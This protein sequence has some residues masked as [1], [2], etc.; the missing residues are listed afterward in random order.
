MR[1]HPVTQRYAPTSDQKELYTLSHYNKLLTITNYSAN[2][3]LRPLYN[4]T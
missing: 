2:L 4:S 3:N 1:E